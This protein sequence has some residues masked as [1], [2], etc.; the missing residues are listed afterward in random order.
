MKCCR[1]KARMKGKRGERRMRD[2]G[3]EYKF[4]RMGR[5]G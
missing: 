2:K 1:C 3:K 4:G 5:G